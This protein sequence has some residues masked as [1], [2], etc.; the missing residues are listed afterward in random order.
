MEREKRGKEK[1]KRER[2]GDRRERGREK[3]REKERE[4][5]REIEREDKRQSEGR[6]KRWREREK[7]FS[8]R[9]TIN[10]KGPDLQTAG[11]GEPV[12]RYRNLV[13]NCYGSSRPGTFVLRHA[14]DIIII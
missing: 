1:R 7:L 2:R 5:E 8:I 4:K 11:A 13:N 10:S 14:T 9:S 3:R 12:Y 6:R